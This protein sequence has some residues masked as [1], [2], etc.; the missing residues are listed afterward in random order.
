MLDAGS[1]GRDAAMRFAIFLIFF[2]FFCSKAFAELHAG[3]GVASITPTEAGIPTQL[4]G[5]GAR[6]GKPAEGVHDTI[7]AKA[8]LL[9]NDGQRVAIVTL[10][11]CTIP[12]CAVEQSI[13][14]AGIEG[15]SYQNTLM[16]ASHTHGGTEGFSLDVRN[17][18]GNPHVGIFS[19]ET[20]D[21]TTD[22][23]AEALKAAAADLRPARAGSLSVMA[24]GFAANRRDD[25]FVDDELTLLRIDGE[26]GKTR[27]VLAGF[28]AHGTFMTEKE[29]LISGDWA[30]HFQRTVEAA[31]GEGVCLYMNGAEGDIRPAGAQGGSRWEMAEDHGRRL[32]LIAARAAAEIETAADP[33]LRLGMRMIPLPPRVPSPDFLKIAGVE[34]GVNEEMLGAMLGPMFPGE[35][36]MYAVRLGDWQAVSMPGEAL[37][38]IG[39]AVKAA[40]RD[41]GVKHPVIAGLTSEHMGY[42]LTEEEYHQSGYEATA[43]FYG[44][45]LG[46]IILRNALELGVEV[47]KME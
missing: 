6:M 26:D 29:M 27:A 40:V 24:P 21:F 1:T 14:K 12:R 46:E 7:K 16:P 13:A 25:D 18:F 42:I 32:G 8:L 9:E 41:E 11:T 2:S 15:I 35:V 38:Q 45:G 44:P 23:I 17:V 37:C 3:V 30:G 47:A 22:R 19:Q 31:L 34:Y 20:L 33:A 10:D 4:G 36:P 5:Y 28:T 39:L 43:S